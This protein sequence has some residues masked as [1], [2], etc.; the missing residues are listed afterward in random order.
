MWALIIGDQGLIDE[1]TAPV[2]VLLAVAPTA[3]VLALVVSWWPGTVATRRP[4]HVLRSE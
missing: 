4:G 2:L 3:V 1:P